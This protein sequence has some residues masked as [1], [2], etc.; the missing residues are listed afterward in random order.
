M[1]STEERWA[2]V[3]DYEGLY[4]VST[5][6]RVR[7]LIRIGRGK[8]KTYGGRILKQYINP[9]N[10]YAYMTLCDDIGG[11]RRRLVRVHVVV[12]RVFLGVPPEGYEV[13]HGNGIRHDNHLTNLSYSTHQDNCADKI[14]HGTSQ[15]G[16]SH[17]SSKLSDAEA[18]EII[19]QYKSGDM[20]QNELAKKYGVS[21]SSISWIVKGKRKI[22][23]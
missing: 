11:R 21:Q 1:I 10:R 17:P 16:E 12:A 3:N 6:G 19:E 13:R 2:P 18:E 7:S 15:R 9:L 14:L 4:E 23:A 5:L 22:A 8:R 20:T